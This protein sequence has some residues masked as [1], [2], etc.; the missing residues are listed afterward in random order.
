MKNQ[1][2]KIIGTNENA[3]DVKKELEKIEQEQKESNQPKR[4]TKT[5]NSDDE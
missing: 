2:A 3:D 1:K 5:F 4:Q